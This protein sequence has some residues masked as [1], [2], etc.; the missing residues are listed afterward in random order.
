MTMSRYEAVHGLPPL[1]INPPRASSSDPTT[2]VIDYGASG[3]RNL[4]ILV[5]GRL[6]SLFDDPFIAVRNHT[7]SAKRS[8]AARRNGNTWCIVEVLLKITR[9]SPNGSMSINLL[10]I[11]PNGSSVTVRAVRDSVRAPASASVPPPLSATLAPLLPPAP[12]WPTPPLFCS[13]PPPCVGCFVTRSCP[14]YS[15]R[16]PSFR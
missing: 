15:D 12:P 11:S 2:M 1:C 13:D 8:G 4:Q 9:R 3:G 14:P 5:M 10:P 16:H 7:L 6:I